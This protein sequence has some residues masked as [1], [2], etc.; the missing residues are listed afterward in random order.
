MDDS[1]SMNA[2]R[3]QTAWIEARDLALRYI[4]TLR[5]GDDATVLFTSSAGS[6]T[7]PAPLYDLDRAREI[8][9]TASPRFEKMDMPHAISVALQQLDSRANPRHEL[10]VFSDM[11]AQG[12]QL[13]DAAR[14][15]FLSDAVHS[16]RVEP[17]IVL[18]SVAR[19]QPAN[20]AVTGATLSRAAVDCFAPVTFNF[21]I[22]NNGPETI[23]GVTVTF[24]A[25]GVTKITRSVDLTANA[26]LVLG[27]EHRFDT[28]GSHY[29]ACA[30]CAAR[31][32]R[33]RMTT[34]CFA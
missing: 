18:A 13:D 3:P 7:A 17:N 32:I 27:F 16:S 28:P 19:H 34:N 23:S 8:V 2:G 9:R 24:A 14:W 29:V 15:S 1:Y 30:G 12:W 31:R 21:S 11:Q 25:D 4:D 20:A 33:S 5:K 10:V 6:G 26:K 22:E